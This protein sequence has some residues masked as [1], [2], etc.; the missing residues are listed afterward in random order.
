MITISSLFLSGLLL[1]SYK[2]LLGYYTGQPAISLLGQEDFVH[3]A[4][5]RGQTNPT[6]LTLSA[7]E[8]IFAVSGK[9]LSLI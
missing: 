8:R 6:G 4:T 7:P 1:L 2:F 3:S 9:C 5:N